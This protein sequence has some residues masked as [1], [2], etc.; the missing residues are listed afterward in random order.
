MLD[1]EKQD[2][3]LVAEARKGSEEA[4]EELIKRHSRYMLGIAYGLLGSREDAEEVVQDAFIKAHGSI[5]SLREDSL[6]PAWLS[7]IVVNMSRNRYKWNKVRGDGLNIS[8]SAQTADRGQDA[9][10][11][12]ELP[13][14]LPSPDKEAENAE[15]ERKIMS[16][17]ERLPD[18]LREAIVLRHV[19][20][21]S[22]KQIADVLGENIDTVKTR[23][24]RGRAAIA[25]R[26]GGK[27]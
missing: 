2:M 6:F 3:S 24:S 4:F 25:A 8:I 21:M 14:N 12:M 19:K 23:I 9:K 17:I 18:T 16:E 10:G 5:A 26:L 11:D 27:L 22:Y 20:D 15:M 7:R 1:S 13:S